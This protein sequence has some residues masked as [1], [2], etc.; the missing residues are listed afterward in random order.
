MLFLY[1][2]AY[3]VMS[4][5]YLPSFAVRLRQADNAPQLVKQRFGILEPAWKERLIGKKII[6]VH[7]VSVG[8]VLA[9]EN[10]LRRLLVSFPGI[11]VVLSTVTPTGQKM[12]QKI[13]DERISAVYFPFDFSFAVRSFFREL[14]P[15]CVILAET[16]M[17][18]NLLA[19]AGR[20]RVPVGIV[21]A[22]LSPRSAK[23]YG[24]FSWIFRP[25]FGALAFVMAQTDA[26]AERFQQLGTAPERIR[27]M[28][29]M[30]YDNVELG[31]DRASLSRRFRAQWGIPETSRVLVA[32]STH[33]GE[34]KILGQVLSSLRE[35]GSDYAD[36]KMIVAPRH[37]E[38]SHALAKELTA[39][40]LRTALATEYKEGAEFEVLLVDQL[41]VLKDLYAMADV[42]FMGGSLI[43]KG[44]Q[45]P[46][47]PAAF[48]RALT[49]G[50]YVFNFERVYRVL[51]DEGGAV[52]VRDE[53]DLLFAL[54][55][56]L[57]HPAE[58]VSLGKNA[59]QTVRSLRG[60]TDRSLEWL[61]QLLAPEP[62]LVKG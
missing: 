13:K 16:E 26:D 29:N 43:P 46:I 42:V 52:M 9:V 23:N 34:E 59:C 17:W 21:N 38:R 48:E 18:P 30:K 10:F 15:E 3:F 12:A 62:Q 58:L 60:A 50:P 55:R 11:H 35:K 56:L 14:E 36:V 37:I 6:W 22:R 8:E 1:N 41:G 53:D 54:E 5:F 19:E 33:P 40:G 61:V 20:F 32:G 44:G 49:H 28:G 4:L 47:E 7:A 24:R 51:G 57:S 45:N 39:M 25:L 31:K 27:V 2:L